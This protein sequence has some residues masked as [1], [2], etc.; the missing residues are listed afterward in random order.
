MSGA[1]RRSSKC[2]PEQTPAVEDGISRQKLLA[3]IDVFDSAVV[4]TSYSDSGSTLGRRLVDV[5]DLVEMF[6]GLGTGKRWIRLGPGVVAAGTDANGNSRCMIVRKAKATTIR[7]QVGKRKMKL[8]MS[9]PNL[10]AELIATKSGK[11]KKLEAVYAFRGKLKNDTQLYVP[12]LPNV[13]ERGGVC[14]G[15]ADIKKYAKLD[16]AEAFEKAFIESIFTDHLTDSALVGKKWRNI[17][18]AI[19]KTKGKVPMKEL[20]KVKRYGQTLK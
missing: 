19:K 11:W 18:D 3:S 14:M 7:C 16:A 10:L 4:A 2:L 12:P 1:P 13:Y 15:S 8:K 20:R 17:I 5:A 6:G 9:M